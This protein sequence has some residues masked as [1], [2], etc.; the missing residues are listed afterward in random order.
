M[1]LRFMIWDLGFRIWDLGIKITKKLAKEKRNN[2]IIPS[3]TPPH[4]DI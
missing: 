3:K 2:I 4:P 1:D